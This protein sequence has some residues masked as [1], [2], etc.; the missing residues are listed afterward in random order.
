MNKKSLLDHKAVRIVSWNVRSH[1]RRRTTVEKLLSEN[2]IV[3]A[4]E[5][6]TRTRPAYDK[7]IS[8]FFK[9]S[10]EGRNAQRGLMILADKTVDCCEVPVPGNPYGVETLAISVHTAEKSFILINVYIPGDA[11]PTAEHW[12]RIL[13]PL[14][15]LGPRVLIMGDFNARSPAWRDTGYNVNGKSLEE[16]L[17]TLDTIILNNDHPTRVAERAGDADSSI[18]LTLVTPSILL[19]LRWKLLPLMGSDHRPVLLHV[20]TGQSNQV[21]ARKQ[22]FHYSAKD[23]TVIGKIRKSVR[24]TRKPSSRSRKQEPAWMTQEVKDAW[25]KKMRRSKEYT[26]SK[27]RA[28]DQAVIQ[29]C[30]ALFDA[31]AA[32]YQ[33]VAAC[34]KQD[35]WDNFCSECDPNDPAVPSNFWRLAKA[36][37]GMERADNPCP[38]QIMGDDDEPLRTDEEKG[39]AFLQR[40][41]RQLQ[42]DGIQ[43]VE[44]AKNKISEKLKDTQG[45]DVD[46]VTLEELETTLRGIGKDSAPGPDRVRYSSLKSM[47]PDDKT[48]LLEVI[49]ESLTTGTVRKDLR[50]CCMA[51]LPKPMKDHSRLKGYRIITMANVWVKIIEKIAAQRLSRDLEGRGCLS[52]RVGGARPGRTTTSNIEAVLHDI[53]QGM[54]EKQHTAVALFDLEDA[55]NKVD[56]GILVDKLLGMD[57][58]LVMVRWILAMLD[59][60]T[61]QMRFGKWSSDFFEVSSG[62]PQGSPL[63]SILFNVYTA[64]LVEAT[65]TN[66]AS[67]YSYVDDVI[68]SKTDKTPEG[69]VEGLQAATDTF[70]KWVEDNRMSAQPDKGCW[71]IA[72]RGYFKPEQFILTFRGAVV[73]QQPSVIYLGTM[74]DRRMSMS[75]HVEHL[76]KKA[77]KSLGLLRFAASQNVRQKSLFQL[78]RATVSSRMEYGLHLCLCASQQSLTKLQRVQNQAMRVVTGAAKPTASETLQ[79]WL[80]INNIRTRQKFLAAEA[81]LRAINTKSHPLYHHLR[82]KEDLEVQQRL[83]TVQSWVIGAREIIEETCPVD[84][85]QYAGWMPAYGIT[86]NT[87]VIG[88]REWRER[89]DCVNQALVMEWIEEQDA[90]III[91]TDGSLRD[92]VTGWGGAVWRAGKRVFEWS[93]A[94]AGRSSSFRAECEAYEDGLTWLA[95]EATVEDRA[96]ILTDSLSLVSKLAKN[97]VKDS[98]YDLFKQIKCHLVTTYIPG[99]CGISYN[100]KADKLA[101]SAEPFGDLIM[102]ARDVLDKTLE[103]LTEKERAVQECKWSTERL[104]ERE[105]NRGD[106]AKLTVRGKDRAVYNQMEFGV[107]TR[108]TLQLIVEGGGPELMPEPLIL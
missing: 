71:M 33:D 14:L 55:Y 37:K 20:M 34:A 69:A 56:V 40:Y 102:T 96:I 25:C 36:M 82:E 72:S 12:N 94:R 89:A 18:D 98:W 108:K 79:Y 90:T 51:I 45:E 70:D 84:S 85:I 29:E 27:R 101:G 3:M 60:R 4:Q 107:V 63:S 91:A 62:L 64:D 21:P 74:M 66:G 23:R 17:P 15:N 59:A 22:R 32:E 50:D 103:K 44:R 58:S 57:V 105:R 65:A 67:P 8:V 106:G 10:T 5:M 87:E 68:I 41:K 49:N 19:D 47:S 73:P 1:N 30:K 7:D 78:M 9:P 100:S 16:A 104:L 53:Q 88:N 95:R 6:K 86:I 83:Q 77:T 39:K 80:G 28:H 2:N 11:L 46:E 31:A 92:D 61:C 35:H 24:E 81:F 43:T 97:R 48:K 99:H 75:L 42:P 38:Q 52:S 54:Q 93:T 76:A 13:D 26:R